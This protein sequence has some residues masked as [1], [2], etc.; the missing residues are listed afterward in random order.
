MTAQILPLPPDGHFSVF[1][2]LPLKGLDQLCGEGVRGLVWG[3]MIAFTMLAH[4][5]GR[6][7]C[8][9]VPC[10][11]HIPLCPPCLHSGVGVKI[12]NFRFGRF[13]HKLK[14][15]ETR[16]CPGVRGG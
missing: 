3:A 8:G 16:K 13:T 9:E 2:D 12:C 7:A 1:E 10:V 14:G 4:Q 5:H 11:V 15:V 6:R